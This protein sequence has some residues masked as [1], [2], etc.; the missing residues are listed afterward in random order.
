MI[1]NGTAKEVTSYKIFVGGLDLDTT[2][3]DLTEYFSKFGKVV[4]RL[5][6]V[7]IKSKKSR[8]FGFIGFKSAD[9]VDKVLEQS[10]HSIRGKKIDCKRAMTKEE[11]YSWNKDL[12]DSFRKV[13]VSNIPRETSKAELTNLFNQYGRV[14]EVNLMFKKKETG[15]CYLVLEREEE[16]IK[17]IDLK[18][19][20]FKGIQLEVKKAIPKDV[21]NSPTDDDSRTKI[22]AH[23]FSTPM[24][25]R[26][27][28]S[29]D[30]PASYQNYYSNSNPAGM[31][32]PQYQKMSH[33][34]YYDA[35]SP[36]NANIIGHR[37]PESMSPYDRSVMGPHGP[38]PHGEDLRY[39][40]RGLYPS[41]MGGYPS[42]NSEGHPVDL[43]HRSRVMSEQQ[44]NTYKQFAGSPPGGPQMYYHP[45][46]MRNPAGRPK[47]MG[48]SFSHA[49]DMHK[50][51][52]RQQHEMESHKMAKN[53]AV[54][55]FTE[56]QINFKTQFPK[57]S[58]SPHPGS[59]RHRS[60]QGSPAEG[61]QEQA[62]QHRSPVD[63]KQ[64][65]LA[66]ITELE[67]EIK[68]TKDKLRMLENLLVTYKRQYET[69]EEAKSYHERNSDSMNNE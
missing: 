35:H 28:H 11:A 8:G 3:E 53:N 37:P 16:A 54:P 14:V 9:A 4:E 52:S 23:Q 64:A 45:A 66:K 18:Y 20:D 49:E 38:M 27:R 61:S 29:F 42:S 31:G 17:L 40:S 69:V 63:T 15:F 60:S 51:G 68:A 5:I 33:M 55:E 59:K 7:D 10:T 6:K 34:K 39:A 1:S 65:K 41:P 24:P 30:T 19:I 26:H 12:K 46:D 21:K 25:V 43:P 62:M 67:E 13:F 50:F 32:N 58:S 48:H 36:H 22:P 47:Y 57:D 2:E 56:N 44:V